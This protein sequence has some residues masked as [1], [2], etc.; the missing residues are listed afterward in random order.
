MNRLRFALATSLPLLFGACTAAQVGGVIHPRISGNVVVRTV[1]GKQTRWTP[2]RCVSGDLAY[3]AGFDFL[4]TR[5]SGQLRAPLDPID[6]PVIRW[7]MADG[8]GPS[9]L[10]LRRMQCTSL[11]LDVQPTGWRVKDVREFAGHLVIACATANG[12]QIE[13]RIDVDHCH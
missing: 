11:D 12:T 8:S 13:G 7:T 10:I 5:D 6:G 4:S 3:F 9:A 2:D 1:D